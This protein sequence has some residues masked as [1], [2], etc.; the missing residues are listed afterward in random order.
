MGMKKVQ[1]YISCG[2]SKNKSKLASHTIYTNFLK[3]MVCHNAF[4]MLQVQVEYFTKSVIPLSAIILFRFPD[5]ACFLHCFFVFFKQ[6]MGK[7]CVLCTPTI[8]TNENCHFH[9]QPPLCNTFP[10]TPFIHYKRAT[11][12]YRC[13]SFAA[14]FNSHQNR[15]LCRYS[16]IILVNVHKINVKW[17]PCIKAHIYFLLI[18]KVTLLA[19]AVVVGTLLRSPVSHLN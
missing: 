17:L 18:K 5:I 8:L 11:G 14:P 6:T 4:F 16:D 7:N 2:I 19:A 1:I 15:N 9:Q 10:A 13:I 12:L 3:G